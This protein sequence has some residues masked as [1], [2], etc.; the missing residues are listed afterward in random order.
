MFR[1]YSD[2]TNYTEEWCQ[3]YDQRPEV[4]LKCTIYDRRYE[5]CKIY[6]S[7]PRFFLNNAHC[8]YYI[9]EAATDPDK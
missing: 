2:A 3:Y 7:E 4:V 1:V 5:G 9:A 8:G 6:P